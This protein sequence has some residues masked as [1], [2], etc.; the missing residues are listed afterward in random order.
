M[1]TT[2]VDESER[3]AARVVG[4]TFLPQMQP[5]SLLWFTEQRIR[6]ALVKQVRN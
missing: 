1:A 2:I 4:F 6:D 3:K 5:P